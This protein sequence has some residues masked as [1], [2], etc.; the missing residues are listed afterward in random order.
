MLY[1]LLTYLDRLYDLPGFQVFQ[2]LTFRAVLA[3]VF[4]LGLSLIVGRR[5]ILYLKSRLVGER[6]RELGPPTHKAKAGTPTMGGLIILTAAVLPTLLW[7]NLTNM[8]VLL[9]LTG[10]VW[11][12]LIGFL[13]DYIKVFR[14]NKSGLH[15]RFK[16]VGQVGLGLLIGL[17]MV[18]HPQFKGD[19]K[20][21]NTAGIVRPNEL[22]RATGFVKGDR[23]VSADGRRLSEILDDDQ[24]TPY[25]TYTVEGTDKRIRLLPVATTDQKAVSEALFGRKTQG[26]ETSTHVPFLKNYVLN[27]QDLAFWA[28]AEDTFWGKL[29]YILVCI[30]IVTAVSNGVNITDGLDGLAAGT[31]AIVLTVLGAFAYISGN[32]IMANYLN[33]SFI[34]YSGELVIFSAALLGACIGFLWYN[35]Y[36]A[37]VFMGDTGSLA[38]GGAV[39]VLA[40]MVK[41]ELLLPLICAV[42]FVE[43]L[44][45]II[46]VSYFK[47]TKRKTGTGVRIF[48]MAPLHHHY[49]LSGWHESKIVTRFW[50]LTILL[51]LL[52][53]ATLKLR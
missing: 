36:P 7:A 13:D 31:T 33:I 42:F 18:N 22:L 9:A 53:F 26:F 52:A 11:M 38:L 20:H 2:Y 32:A 39:G 30:F 24:A 15:G 27:Y 23:I 47:Y 46:Q 12:G 44:S 10:L 40:L 8:Y 35:A 34:P 25:A 43:S 29:I 17:V 5:I 16:V 49:E 48:K 6:I 45:V 28:P 51:E 14:K 4:S 3:T 19:K 1:A 50:I 37:Q 21:T 41:K